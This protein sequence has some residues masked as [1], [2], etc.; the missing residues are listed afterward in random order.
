[1]ISK[2]MI[3]NI[4]FDFNG[5]ILNDLE[6]CCN[7]E[8]VMMERNGLRPYTMQEYLDK[9]FFPVKEYYDCI[10]IKDENFLD[11][12]DFFNKQYFSRWSKETYLYDGIVEAL[13]DLKKNGYRLFVLSATKQEFLDEQLKFLGIYDMFEGTCGARNDLGGSKIEYGKAYAKLHYVNPNETIM[14]G[15]TIHDYEVSKELGFDCLLF[16]KGHNSKWRLEK[17]G[18]KTFDDYK[19]LLEVVK[20]F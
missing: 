16:T 6:L 7:I 12:A 14:I 15:D 3:K 10:G 20:T 13:K 8:Q 1:M 9:F 11:A 2:F 4:F 17:L 5:T 19:N 18:V